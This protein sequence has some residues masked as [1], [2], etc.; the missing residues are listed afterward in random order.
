MKNSSHM[1]FWMTVVL[2][3]F[4][5]SPLFRTGPAMEKFLRQEIV[6]T[7]HALGDVTAEKVVGFAASLF[8][9]S[10]LSS[11]ATG[12]SSLQHTDSDKRL[13]KAVAGAAGQVVTGLF[14]S[15][16]QGLA[17]EAFIVAMRFTIAMVWI[18]LL[19]PFLFAA[20]YDGFMLRKIK[21]AEFGVIRPAT[22]TIAGMI[23]IPLLALPMVYLV[24]PFSMSPLLA[25]AWAFCVA[26]PLAVMISNMQPIFGR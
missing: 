10:P 14:D 26:L 2:V 6:D 8:E 11:I 23:V 3:G 25:P 19:S 9:A 12:A 21:R 7:R 20:V 18:I 5:L 1:G 16:V 17:M 24:M 13:T 15:Y 22:F 4:L